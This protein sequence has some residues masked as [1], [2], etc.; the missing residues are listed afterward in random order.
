MPTRRRTE[1]TK[2]VTD[3]IADRL[4]AALPAKGVTERRMFG[5]IGFMLDGNLVCAA[6]KRGVLL[7]VGKEGHQD[8]L[9]R[10]AKA[11]EMRGRKLEGYVFVDPASLE[12]TALRRWIETAVAHVRT[13]PPKSKPA[14]KRPSR[15][16]R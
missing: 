13:L 12:E 2:P 16:E 15:S 7:R 5:G 14:P 3:S 8:A 6:S 11:M 9:A 4:R 1:P 10:G